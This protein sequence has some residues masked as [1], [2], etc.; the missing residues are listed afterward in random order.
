MARSLTSGC[1][2]NIPSPHK[3][4]KSFVTWSN[5]RKLPAA[6]LAALGNTVPCSSGKIW[7][8]WRASPRKS[9]PLSSASCAIS[10]PI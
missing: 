8:A 6:A 10:A 7:N 3:V 5:P 4:G 1:S 9:Q 2:M